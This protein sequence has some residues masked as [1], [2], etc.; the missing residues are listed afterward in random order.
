MNG[1][2]FAE[3]NPLLAIALTYLL[4]APVRYAYKAY[5][6]RL[7]HKNILAHGWPIPPVDADGDIIKK[8]ENDQ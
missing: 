8:E 3:H 4:M 2:Q 7:R 6:R 5:N 1:W